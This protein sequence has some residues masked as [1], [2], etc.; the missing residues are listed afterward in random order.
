[1][2]ILYH[3]TSRIFHKWHFSMGS[4]SRCT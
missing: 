1:M 3:R 4:G 2:L